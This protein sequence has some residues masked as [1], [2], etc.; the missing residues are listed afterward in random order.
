MFG[1]EC[2]VRQK[3]ADVASIG[4]YFNG[5][6]ASVFVWRATMGCRDRSSRAFFWPIG[7]SALEN[8][9]ADSLLL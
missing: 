8:S 9:S 7:S 6:L 2:V 4:K 1:E 5:R 3:T